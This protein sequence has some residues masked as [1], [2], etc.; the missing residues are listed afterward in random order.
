MFRPM[1]RIKQQISEEACLE[2]L[3]TAPRGTLAVLGDDGYPYA[4]PLDFAYA[5]GCLYFHC[6]KEGHKLDAIRGC[7]KASFCV[8]GEG[9]QNPGEW[10]YY[11]TSVICFGRVTIIEDAETAREK[12]SLLGAKYMPTME[13]VAADIAKNAPRAVVLEMKI[14]HMTGKRVQEK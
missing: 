9:A 10:W 3:R 11:F 7:D 2:I 6:A 4:V 1:R 5:D 13:E 14:E 8:L 12:L